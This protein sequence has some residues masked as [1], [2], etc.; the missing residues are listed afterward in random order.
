MEAGA[1]AWGW[2]LAVM[3]A[4]LVLGGLVAWR[5][6]RGTAAASA[7][8]APPLEL[9]DL[10]GRLD[11]LVLQ[12]RELQDLAAKRSPEQ[13]AR[14]R[15]ALELQAAE[16]L[17]ERERSAPAAA[18]AGKTRVAPAGQG[19]SRAGLRDSCGARARPPRWPCC[20]STV[21]PV[22]PREEGGSR[23]PPAS[24]VIPWPPAGTP[25]ADRIAPI[26][27]TA[28]ALSPGLRHPLLRVV[29]SA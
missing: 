29:Q 13:L 20:S 11:V 28:G 21:A 27:P 24:T 3:A 12:L 25:S 22:K 19:A 6:R 15:Y 14:E 26:A 17:R 7:A 10:D 2:P 23:S 1:T 18:P 4:G 8:D 16:V 5:M 9:R